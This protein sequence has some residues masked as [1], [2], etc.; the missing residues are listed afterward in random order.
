LRLKDFFTKLNKLRKK[1][2]FLILQTVL[3][4]ISFEKIK[5]AVFYEL[6]FDGAPMHVNAKKTVEIKK[7]GISD[8]E[9][10]V[11]CQNKKDIFLK[12][13]KSGEN[14]LL[15]IVDGQ[16]V[17]Y[18]WFCTGA[19]HIEER[20]GYEITIPAKVMYAYDAYVLPTYRKQKI[21]SQLL[22]ASSKLMT[23]NNKTG[24]LSFVD[25]GNDISLNVHKKFGFLQVKSILFLKFFGL[26]FS[27]KF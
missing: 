8:I 19:K 1:P 16:V 24:I 14:C 11:S 3:S 10:L 5:I 20:Y 27:M 13:F 12:R 2:I 18:E 6:R 9:K 22:E 26:T 25:Y 4:K 23:E 17:G 15:A 7:G 21:W